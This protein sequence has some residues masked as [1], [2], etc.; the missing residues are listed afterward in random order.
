MG[1]S[2]AQAYKN[3]SDDVRS[4][5]ADLLVHLGLDVANI[6]DKAAIAQ[7][8]EALA[9]P[10]RGNK[11]GAKKTEVDGKKFDSQKE[12]ARYLALKAQEEA[13]EISSLILQCEIQLM[14]G[15]TYK[16]EKVRPIR[17]TCD[18]CYAKN[19][20]TY[21]EDVK[22]EAT[23]KSEAFRIRWRLLLWYYKD[24]PDVQCIIVD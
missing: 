22:S 6:K 12:A 14:P 17:Y 23:K 24:V 15:F 20:V 5:N 13:G 18:F 10:K 21:I 7:F 9:P 11:Y 4:L 1:Q 16:G 2:I 3:F 8:Q 19:G